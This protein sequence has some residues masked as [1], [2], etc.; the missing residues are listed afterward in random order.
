LE[1]TLFCTF[2]FA[3]HVLDNAEASRR[4]KVL[5]TMYLAREFRAWV[6]VRERQRSGRLH[7]HLVGTVS[8]DIRTG[9]DFE[10]FAAERWTSA[11]KAL[12]DLWA[13]MREAA[14]LYGFGRT[15]AM[16]IKSTVE[17]VS[18]YVGKYIAKNIQDRQERDAGARLVMYSQTMQREG[19]YLKPNAFAWNSPRAWLWRQRVHRVAERCGITE[20]AQ[21]AEYFGPRWA[22]HLAK[23]VLSEAL[24]EYNERGDLVTVYP[25]VSHARADGHQVPAD[26]AEVGQ[27]ITTRSFDPD[28]DSR[29]LEAMVM[30]IRKAFSWDRIRREN[31]GV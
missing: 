10:E 2:T 8:E 28:P 16:P 12:R 26:A 19:D 18:R 15:E 14:K 1:R 25:S 30:D 20:P 9:V 22:W 13:R 24:G 7:F 17:G 29:D 21:F 5:R 31:E 23:R 11:P 6:A 27:V 3:E 4:W